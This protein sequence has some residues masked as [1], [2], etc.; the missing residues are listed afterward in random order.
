MPSTPESAGGPSTVRRVLGFVAKALVS[1]G[2]LA[3]LLS[4]TD[5]TRLWMHLLTAS[6]LWLLAALGLYLVAMLGATWRWALLLDAQDIDVP[7]RA[8]FSSYLVATF[9]NNFLPSNI[10]GDV[11]RIRDTGRPAQ[12]KTLATTVILI[13]RGLGLFA[14]VLVAAV[15]ATAVST[16]GRGAVPISAVWLWLGLAVGAGIGAPVVM[17]PAAVGRLLQP[18]RVLHPEWVEERIGRITQALYRFRSRPAALLG[19]F[20]GAVAVQMILVVFYAAVARSLA[21]PVPMAHLAVLVPVSFVVQMLPVSMNGL[22]VREA[23]F[24][25][26]FARLGLPLESALLLS[27]LGAGLILLFSLSGATVYLLRRA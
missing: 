24:S 1:A 12:S 20:G 23:V 16:P 9:F 22:G 4:R 8:L 14:L 6:P 3:L 13:D 18:L 19:C 25:V 26:Y 11:I 5:A 27:F 7:R 15:G 2:L 10:G 21:I 17:A